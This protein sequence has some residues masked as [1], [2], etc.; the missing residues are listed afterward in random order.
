MNMFKRR[1]IQPTCCHFLLFV[2]FGVVNEHWY[3]AKKLQKVL[4]RSMF[5]GAL[6]NIF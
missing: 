5:L 1:F 2:Y 4:L 3:I 6:L